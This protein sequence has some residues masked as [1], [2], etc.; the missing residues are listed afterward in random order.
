MLEYHLKVLKELS[1]DNSI[2]QRELSRRL[3]LSLGKINY[4]IHSLRAKGLV[5]AKRFK[6]SKNKIAYKYILTPHGMRKEMEL[7][8]EFLKRKMEEYDMLKKEIERLKRD[9]EKIEAVVS[10][11]E[12]PLGQN[13]E[14]YG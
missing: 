10:E 5:K 11:R 6:N 3:G 2:S 7:T 8:Y 14:N 12:E 13:G 9:V 1:R 4:L